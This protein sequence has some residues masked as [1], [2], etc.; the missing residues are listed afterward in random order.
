MSNLDFDCTPFPKLTVVHACLP[1][2]S[3]FGCFAQEGRLCELG[4]ERRRNFGCVDYYG[5]TASFCTA[6]LITR[7]KTKYDRFVMNFCITEIFSMSN[8]Y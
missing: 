6:Y 5:H 7:H 4:A 8:Y 3:Q 1:S 2:A